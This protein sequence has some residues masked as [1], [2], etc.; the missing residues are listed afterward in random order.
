MKNFKTTKKLLSLVLCVL[1]VFSTVSI[2]SAE[3][4]DD[5]PAGTL[6]DCQNGNHVFGGYVGEVIE[7]T[8]EKEGLE[9][10]RCSVCDEKITMIT[11]KTGHRYDDEAWVTIV[12]AQHTNLAIIQ[13]RRRNYCLD[14]NEMQLEYVNIPHEFAEDDAGEIMRYPTCVSV[15]GTLKKCLLCEKKQP[16]ELPIDEN[17]HVYDGVYFT[18]KA[19]TCTTPGSGVQVCIYCD[20]VENVTN[21]YAE[22]VTEAHS[23]IP[24]T[25]VGDNLP[26]NAV[27][28]DGQVAR[29]AKIC[30]DCNVI[31]DETTFSAMHE[32]INPVGVVATCSDYGYAQG[33]CNKCNSNAKNTLLP[34][35]SKHVWMEDIVVEE[36]TCKNN[37]R[38]LRRCSLNR[39]HAEFVTVTDGGHKF[40]NEWSVDVAATCK[41]PGTKSNTCSVCKVKFTEEIPVDESLH[42]FDEEN[43]TKEIIDNPDCDI[44]IKETSE[45]TV[46]HAAMEREILNHD[47]VKVGEVDPTCG[48]TGKIFY[49]CS[50][51]SEDKI[52]II[53]VDHTKHVGSGYY[54]VT[55][56]PTCTTDGVESELCMKCKKAIPTSTK[57]VPKTGHNASK[58]EWKI[59]DGK[60]L[61][62]TCDSSGAQV[63]KCTNK[64]C[65][66][67]IT[68]N[69]NPSHSYTAWAY[70]GGGKDS[71]TCKTPVTRTRKCLVETCDDKIDQEEY[72]GSH[73]PGSFRF[74]SGNCTTGG[75][76]EAVCGCCDKVYKVFDVRQGEHVLDKSSAVDLIVDSDMKDVYCG[77]KLYT[78][79]LC[80]SEV[81]LSI[82]HSYRHI[83]TEEGA[84]EPTC[85]LSGKTSKKQCIDCYH[86]FE[87]KDLDPLGHNY[88]WG[89]KGEI[90]CS[91]CGD[92]KVGEEVN[93]ETGET[94]DVN[95]RHFCHNNGTF[96]KILLKVLTIFWKMFGI[97]Q[98]CD[99]GAVHYETK[100]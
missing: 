84:F 3:T 43:S 89:S 57:T 80:E 93:P 9:T 58:W 76:V 37:G 87:Q 50:K 59:V 35:S 31:V 42:I 96:A 85:T 67:S 49:K 29:L 39:A 11:P 98:E 100:K 36:A 20:H 2:A 53:P 91:R 23:Y 56:D 15:G 26:D 10:Y 44:L 27:C 51:C 46:C 4:Q 22:S 12:E 16:V 5:A 72:Y 86:I 62:S 40:E 7:A 69:V 99:C 88:V 18:G 55:T 38:I 41:D 92:F 66:F 65:S 25:I 17:A 6:T 73:I 77:S 60:V 64:D 47:F 61:K 1:M 30:P 45:C 90:Y 78:C 32:I 63:R 54:Y 68:M 21:V 74:L 28:S 81:E 8:C 19:P 48:E 79:Y 52:V 34:D 82:R 70:S 24:W 14:C 94:E 83:D 71:A 97:N 33:I 75:T 95:C 13:G